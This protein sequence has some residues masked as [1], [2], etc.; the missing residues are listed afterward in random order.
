MPSTCCSPHACAAEAVSARLRTDGCVDSAGSRACDL[1]ATGQ[2]S[3]HLSLLSAGKLAMMCKETCSAIVFPAGRHHSEHAIISVKHISWWF[4]EACLKSSA[5]K[6]ETINMA[7]TVG[8]VWAAC[9][10]RHLLRPAPPTHPAAAPH[11]VYQAAR[12][13]LGSGRVPHAAPVWAICPL[14]R[15]PRPHP[16]PACSGDNRS[17][18]R[19]VH[20]QA[21]SQHTKPQ[22]SSKRQKTLEHLKALTATQD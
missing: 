7:C 14:L 4:W 2:N 17:E 3:Q 15:L 11:K 1:A 19:S 18:E 21:W 5:G 13:G 16:L 6:G 12:L 22:E 20:R 10:W 9:T 8:E